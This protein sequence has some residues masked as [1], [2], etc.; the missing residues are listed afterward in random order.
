M[1][2]RSRASA[3]V[4]SLRTRVRTHL[5]ACCGT[6]GGGFDLVRK[7]VAA[8][9][10]GSSEVSSVHAPSALLELSY[11]RSRARRVLKANGKPPASRGAPHRTRVEIRSGWDSATVLVISSVSSRRV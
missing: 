6:V 9:R 5:A 4:R 7:V 11:P 2:F 8:R 10:A 1:R 3:V